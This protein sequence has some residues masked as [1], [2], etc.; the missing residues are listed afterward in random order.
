MEEYYNI[1]ETP[2]IIIEYDTILKGLTSYEDIKE[3][4]GK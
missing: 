1:E 4:L 3:A 2:T